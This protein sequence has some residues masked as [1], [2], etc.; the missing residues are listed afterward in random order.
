M[1]LVEAGQTDLDAPIQTYLPWFELADKEASATITVRNLLNQAPGIST[2]GGNRF[3]AS[4]AALEE[5]VRGLDTIQLTQP[6]DV[7]FYQ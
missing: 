5:T 6:D 3:W 2:K 7:H 4:Q 1:Q